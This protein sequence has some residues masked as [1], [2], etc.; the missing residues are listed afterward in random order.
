MAKEMTLLNR[1]SLWM[2]MCKSV[3]TTNGVAIPLVPQ[4]AVAAIVLVEILSATFKQSETVTITLG[5]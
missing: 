4:Q 2:M 3:L 5:K 1:L